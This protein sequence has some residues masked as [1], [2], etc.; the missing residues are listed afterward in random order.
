MKKRMNMSYNKIQPSR[1]SGNDYTAL[2]KH[3]K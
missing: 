1:I 3:Y 2:N